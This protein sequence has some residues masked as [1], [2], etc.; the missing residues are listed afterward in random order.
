MSRKF[1]VREQLGFANAGRFLNRFISFV[2]FTATSLRALSGFAVSHRI[3]SIASCMRL[4]S[5]LSPESPIPVVK[6]MFSPC[7]TRGLWRSAA[8]IFG[9]VGWV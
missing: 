1:E 3:D 6:V 8:E 4:S 9:A 5:P 7:L 2:L